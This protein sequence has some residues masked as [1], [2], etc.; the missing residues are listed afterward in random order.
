[1]CP[2]AY[3][4][5]DVLHLTGMG[6]T[7]FYKL[8]NSGDLKARKLGARTVVLAEYL[9]AWLKGLPSYP[10]KG[11]EVGAI[12]VSNTMHSGSG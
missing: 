2:K 6:R 4:V 5:K 7:K 3:T 1:M 8:V 10:L 12:S 11:T 9:D